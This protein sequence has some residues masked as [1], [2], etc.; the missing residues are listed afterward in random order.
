MTPYAPVGYPRDYGS[1]VTPLLQLPDDRGTN[2]D[3]TWCLRIS[4]Q[5]R[6][7]SRL[8]VCEAAEACSSGASSS[9]IQADRPSRLGLRAG[10]VFAPYAQTLARQSAGEVD[11]RPSVHTV[12]ASAIVEYVLGAEG[13]LQ[14][15]MMAEAF[16]RQLCEIHDRYL[17]A[18][19]EFA[20][21]RE[22]D[23]Q[24]EEY[25]HHVIFGDDDAAEETNELSLDEPVDSSTR[26]S[27]TLVS[28]H[29]PQPYI[30][31]PPV[32]SFVVPS[33]PVA[34]LTRLMD[35]LRTEESLSDRRLQT[36]AVRG[37]GV[38]A[39]NESNRALMNS[40]GA[41][42]HT[43]AMMRSLS[44]DAALI[45]CAAWSLVI[46]TR[47]LGA[48]EGSTYIRSLNMRI[49]AEETVSAVDNPQ[50]TGAQLIARLMRL[51]SAR[52]AVLA[53][54]SWSLVNLSVTESRKHIIVD[55]GLVE[56]VCDNLQRFPAHAELVYRSIF[57]LV[58]LVGMPAVQD[59][60]MTRG[61]VAHVVHAMQAFPYY[62]SLQRSA[63]VV[64]RALAYCNHRV[65]DVPGLLPSLLRLHLHC[66]PESLHPN[67]DIRELVLLAVDCMGTNVAREIEMFNIRAE[68]TG[69]E[70][71]V[72]VPARE[73]RERATSGSSAAGAPDSASS[74][75]MVPT[76]LSPAALLRDRAEVERTMSMRRVEA[77]VDWHLA[78]AAANSSQ[79]DGA[80]GTDEFDQQIHP[81][82]QA[83]FGRPLTRATFHHAIRTMAELAQAQPLA[84]EQEP[85]EEQE[86]ED[87]EEQ[88][89]NE[90]DAHDQ[91]LDDED[92]SKGA[93]VMIVEHE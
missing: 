67:P 70:P 60:L 45:A 26:S 6:L 93:P 12:H 87:E 39:L 58:N 78:D 35:L 14:R 18:T 88:E 92:E 25:C 41:V 48:S 56:C 69:T 5:S 49:S 57:C 15:P 84:G 65:V 27:P 59:R 30:Y 72:V 43:L 16:L 68:R 80:A 29:L 71:L 28:S 51:H 3:P 10:L 63:V 47:P 2:S 85:E 90:R 53:K 22:L 44:D 75:R 36:L 62:W 32:D 61:V 24:G 42:A 37:L 8:R 55:A 40:I 11:R 86:E 77:I 81:L 54:L 83:L 91:E 82:S 9:S 21:Q 20:H 79:T 38:L 76:P 46:F 1:G 74:P 7:H 50:E 73:V 64:V 17:I 31:N 23:R 4:L 89:E 52:P 19:A 34:A 33:V 66:M 13:R